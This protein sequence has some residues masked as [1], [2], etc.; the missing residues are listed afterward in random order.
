MEYYSFIEEVSAKVRESGRSIEDIVSIKSVDG[1]KSYEWF[2][3][4][5]LDDRPSEW[6]ITISF[7][8]DFTLTRYGTGWMYNR[9]I[10]ESA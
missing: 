10:Q 3:L 2:E 6:D 5:E 8:D 4:A 7:A 9:N 1:H